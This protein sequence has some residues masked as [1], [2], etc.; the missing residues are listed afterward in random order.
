MYLVVFLIDTN[1]KKVYPVLCVN[2]RLI[3]VQSNLRRK[4]LE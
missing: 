3:C 2:I 1:D 4:N